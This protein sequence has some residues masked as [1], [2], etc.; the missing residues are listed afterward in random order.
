MVVKTKSENIFEEFCK[1][2]NLQWEKI[3]ERDD[4]TPDYK[5]L[6]DAETIIVEVKQIDQDDGKN[7]VREEWH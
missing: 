4:P 2:N 1:E 6:L 3:L 7:R 5:V